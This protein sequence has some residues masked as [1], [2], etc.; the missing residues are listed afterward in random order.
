MSEASFM[1]ALQKRMEATV[2]NLTSGSY[3]QRV[4]ASHVLALCAC[5]YMGVMPCHDGG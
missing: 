4:Q 1:E 2:L 5:V 3:A